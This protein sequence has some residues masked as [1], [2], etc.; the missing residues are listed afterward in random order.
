MGAICVFFC[1][2]NCLDSLVIG[3][4]PQVQEAQ[5][6]PQLSH[7]AINS[8]QNNCRCCCFLCV[9][10]LAFYNFSWLLCQTP[11]ILESV[12]GLVGQGSV[13]CDVVGLQA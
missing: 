7:A 9:L 8:D 10:F 2:V 1:V 5:V 12:L 4:L 13:Y 11:S 6:C 3:Q